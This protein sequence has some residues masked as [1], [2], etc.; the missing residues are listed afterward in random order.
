M[1]AEEGMSCKFERVCC[2]VSR[3]RACPACARSESVVPTCGRVHTHQYVVM[4]THSHTHTCD[5]ALITL[6]SFRFP[7]NLAYDREAP[8]R[9]Q[10]SRHVMPMIFKLGLRAYCRSLCLCT[11][12]LSL[13]SGYYLLY[14]INYWYIYMIYE[15]WNVIKEYIKPYNLPYSMLLLK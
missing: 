1:E 6:H 11:Y 15:C 7:S 13:R 14:M 2:E 10:R 5:H 9:R 12:D 3:V 8:K 4:D